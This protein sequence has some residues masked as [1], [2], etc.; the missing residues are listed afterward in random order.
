MASIGNRERELLQFCSEV[1]A[2]QTD[3][4][5]QGQ[6]ARCEVHDA[7]YSGSHEL[8]GRLLGMCRRDRD[9]AE[10]DM[11]LPDYVAELHG[12]VHRDTF[13]LRA[14]DPRV[15]V[16]RR[17]NAESLFGKSLV[18]EQGTAHVADANHR[19]DPLPV[20]A[21]D[22]ADFSD[23]LVAAIADAGMPKVAELGQV[24]SHLGVR[25]TQHFSELARA[26]RRAAFADEL[27]KL[28][29]VQA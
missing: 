11:L 19:N 25:H 22:A 20:G 24:F 3:V 2:D 1:D 6:R 15:R 14:D 5:W 17:D 7:G 18:A 27:A 4:F 28:A 8:I 29:Q 21:Q 9:H 23:Q 13:N 12:V 10:L 26:N 16:E